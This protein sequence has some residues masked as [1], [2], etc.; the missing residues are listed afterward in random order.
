M[1]AAEDPGANAAE[2]A[3]GAPAFLG[4]FEDDA[5]GAAK[6]LWVI[7]G[8]SGFAASTWISESRVKIFIC[9]KSSQTRRSARLRAVKSFYKYTKARAKTQFPAAHE[10]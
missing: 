9:L 4:A 8:L 10:T 3:A 7:R 6:S 1:S 5:A 2:P